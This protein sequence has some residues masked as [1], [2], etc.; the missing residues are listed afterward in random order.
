VTFIPVCDQP[1]R[2]TQPGHPLVGRRNEYQ[3]RGCDALR[4]EV[5]TRN[6]SCV[7]GR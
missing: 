6:V 2:S 1:P 4:L 3:P 7:C 5:Q